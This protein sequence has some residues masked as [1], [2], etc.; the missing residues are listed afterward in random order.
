MP[1]T[2]THLG[3]RVCR[4]VAVAAF[5]A[6]MLVPA[7]ETSCVTSSARNSFETSASR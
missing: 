1:G 5:A 7:T 3:Q 2:F 6:A 4:P